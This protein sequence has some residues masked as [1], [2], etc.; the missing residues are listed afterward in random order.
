MSLAVW[1]INH[2]MTQEVIIHSPRQLSLNNPRK[3]R[4]TSYR[5]YMMRL[6]STSKF[7]SALSCDILET[8]HTAYCKEV[9]CLGNIVPFVLSQSSCKIAPQ[10]LE[11][12]IELYTM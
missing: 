9:A 12:G 6:M 10:E 3:Y 2:A 7:P 5:L 11:V 1:E 8:N 4:G